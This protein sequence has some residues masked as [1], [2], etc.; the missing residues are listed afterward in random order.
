MLVRCKKTFRDFEERKTRIEGE[1]FEVTPERYESINATKYG[2]LV[3]AVE[4]DADNVET[5]TPKKRPQ[6]RKAAE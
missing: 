2:V 6:R 4:R 1:E 3:E 5:D